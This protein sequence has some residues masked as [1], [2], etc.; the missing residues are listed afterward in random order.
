MSWQ[1][2]FCAGTANPLW[3]SLRKN[4]LRNWSSDKKRWRNMKERVVEIF[5]GRFRKEFGGFVPVTIMV[6]VPF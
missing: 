2:P 1:G 3:I 4:K 6:Y 5:F